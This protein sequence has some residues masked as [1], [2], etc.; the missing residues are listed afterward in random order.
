M[1]SID[2]S[3]LFTQ[4]LHQ[5]LNLPISRLA[6]LIKNFKTTGV[7]LAA[8]F[9]K[10]LNGAIQVEE[11]TVI[12]A[13]QYME[14][15]QKVNCMQDCAWKIF[16]GIIPFGDVSHFLDFL[17]SKTA[18]STKT[19]ECSFSALFTESSFNTLSFE[20][21]KLTNLP[22][23]HVNLIQHFCIQVSTSLVTCRSKTG[24]LTK[25]CTC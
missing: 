20:Y 24:R 7:E 11:L 8:D 25:R 6:D 13:I 4:R 1:D 22:K 17:S 5:N 16:S 23:H 15:F 10:V 2:I 3:S 14:S 21:P 18:I 19:S 12:D 9:D